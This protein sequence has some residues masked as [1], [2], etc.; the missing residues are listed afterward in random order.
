LG[1]WELI[2]TEQ[3]AG[4]VVLWP[5]A[6]II[7]VW[8]YISIRFPISISI[9]IESLVDIRHYGA[10]SLSPVVPL[11][12]LP[13]IISVVFHNEILI[14]TSINSICCPTNFAADVCHIG[15]TK[16]AKLFPGY[17]TEN[18]N[19]VNNKGVVS[20]YSLGNQD[21]GIIPYLVCKEK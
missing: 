13:P 2:E 5:E 8:L 18:R 19:L 9:W 17:D 6:K 3:L 14:Y 11:I 21:Q 7:S 10:S 20:Y 1:G 12:L 4:M 16:R 15:I